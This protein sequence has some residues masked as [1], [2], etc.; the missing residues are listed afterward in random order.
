MGFFKSLGQFA[1]EVT[2]KVLGGT[3]RVV[4]EVAGSQFIKDIGNGVEKATINTGKTAGQL[5]SGVFDVAKGVIKQD[6]N[7]VDSGL[8]D[9]GGAISNTAKGVVS[10]AKYVYNSGKDVVVGI[11][12]DDMDK[13]KQGAKGLVAAAA[14][15]VIAVGIIDVV[16]GADVIG[17]LNAAEADV[18]GEVIADSDPAP[19]TVEHTDSGSIDNPNT[20]HVTPHYVEGYYRADGIYVDGYFRDGDGDTSLNTTGGYEQHNPDYKS[21]S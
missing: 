2:G 19:T 12:D 8:G 5:A 13:V 11:K 15:S 18:D 14:V 4:G 17:E 20:H 16:D 3:V 6:G 1:G 7:V 9:I 10:S 21:K